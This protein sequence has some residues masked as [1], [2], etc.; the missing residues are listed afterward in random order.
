M[1]TTKPHQVPANVFICLFSTS[2]SHFRG[3]IKFIHK[4]VVFRMLLACF[5]MQNNLSLRLNELL[6][7]LIIK[8]VLMY[9]KI[10]KRKD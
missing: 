5:T 7:A 6:S 8:C 1:T 3:E 10:K 4:L 9:K 2:A